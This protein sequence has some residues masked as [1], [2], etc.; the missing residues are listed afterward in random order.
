[1]L[2]LRGHGNRD[3][4]VRA[5]HG[6]ETEGGWAAEDPLAF[7]LERLLQS[8]LRQRGGDGGLLIPGLAAPPDSLRWAEA[9]LNG[10]AVGLAEAWRLMPERPLEGLAAALIMQELAGT[11]PDWALLEGVPHFTVPL[12]LVV[13]PPPAV[14]PPGPVV[15]PEPP[16]IVP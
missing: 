2:V 10:Q 16:V 3:A 4:A 7:A 9:L 13:P 8:G 1:L 6:G 12:A 14:A 5:L 11:K 15:L